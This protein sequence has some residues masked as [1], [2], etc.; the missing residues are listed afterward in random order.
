MTSPVG[1]LGNLVSVNGTVNPFLDVTTE[2]VR[3]RLLNASNARVYRFGLADNRPF[4]LI[5]TDGG[6]LAA[7]HHTSRV[8]LSPGERAE[9]VVA[10]RP[11]ERVILR[12]Y[13]PVLDASWWAE[14]FSGGDDTLDILQLRAAAS[15]PPLRPCP[16]PSL[17]PHGWRR[18]PQSCATWSWPARRSTDP[19]P[20]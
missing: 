19:R 11:G 4:A 1:I 7:P 6:L 9:I 2:R 12:S 18:P 16:A 3:L 17:H 15:L 20:T 13:P 8:Q 14:R 10:V 5:A